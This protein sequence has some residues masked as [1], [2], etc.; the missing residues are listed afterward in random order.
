MGKN[1]VKKELC[2]VCGKVE[3]SRVRPPLDAG[4]LDTGGWQVPC[5]FCKK[6]IRIPLDETKPIEAAAI[7]VKG[8]PIQATEMN[9]FEEENKLFEKLLKGELNAE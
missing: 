3:I 6:L 2:P 4:I 5:S 1:C 9:Y 7:L 8:K